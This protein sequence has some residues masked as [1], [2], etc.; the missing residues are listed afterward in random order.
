MFGATMFAT[1]AEQTETALETTVMRIGTVPTA[2]QGEKEPARIRQFF[3]ETLYTNPSLIT[4]EQGKAAL[5]LEMADSI[6]T[7]RLT[8]MASTKDGKLGANTKGIQVFQD[9]FVDIDLERGEY[10]E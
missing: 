8:A 10:A 7:W 1:T 3:P 9:F 5:N 6:T 2:A 4:D